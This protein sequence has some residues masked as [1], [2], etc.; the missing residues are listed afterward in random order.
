MWRAAHQGTTL[1]LARTL[2]GGLKIWASC[3]ARL[4]VQATWRQPGMRGRSRLRLLRTGSFLSGRITGRLMTASTTRHN[5]DPAASWG[6]QSTGRPWE[7]NPSQ[8][9]R[10][11]VNSTG[12]SRSRGPLPRT[13]NP[14]RGRCGRRSVMLLMSR[15]RSRTYGMTEKTPRFHHSS[16]PRIQRF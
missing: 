13:S 15:P 11:T 7:W 12:S 8:G 5:P 1:S 16:S 3:R 10:S 14:F 2:S 9:R 4:H 6:R